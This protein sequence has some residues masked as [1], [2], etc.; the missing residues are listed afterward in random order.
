MSIVTIILSGGKGKRLWPLSRESSPKQFHSLVEKESL[1]QSTIKRAGRLKQVSDLILIC[2]ESQRFLVDK[3]VK[4]IKGKKYKII[5]EGG[6]IHL[7]AAAV[8]LLKVNISPF[9][10]FFFATNDLRA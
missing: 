1:L 4:E 10:I 5:L 8:K 2:N 6:L 3:Q 7:L 9:L